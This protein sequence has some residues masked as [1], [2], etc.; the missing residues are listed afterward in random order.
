MCKAT[1]SAIHGKRGARDACIHRTFYP[2]N[3]SA[4]ADSEKRR[5]ELST[6]EQSLGKTI[7]PVH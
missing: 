2:V 7:L 6:A 4:T 1:S 3:D 5:F